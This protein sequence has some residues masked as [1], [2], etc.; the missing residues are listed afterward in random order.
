MY[1]WGR[2]YHTAERGGRNSRLDELQAALLRVKL[3]YLD[4]GN[5]ARRERAG[6][7]AQLLAGLPL[8]LPSDVPG[9][10]YHLYVIESDRRDEL[11][12][13]LQAVGIGCDVHYPEP[14]HLQPAYVQLGY[15]V[16]SLP[17]TEALAGRILSLPMFPELRRAEGE[18]V[19]SAVI[20]GLSS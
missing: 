9:H 11:R 1:G 18:Q 14:A 6:W 13:H 2:K 7:Y 20:Q 16:G 10:V 17:H 12:A 4:A 3:R 19:A 5:A 15:R 8:R